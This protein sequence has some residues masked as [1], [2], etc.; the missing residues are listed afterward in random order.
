V[1]S[2]SVT[3]IPTNRTCVHVLSP[4]GNH[5]AQ[6]PSLPLVLLKIQWWNPAASASW[7]LLQAKRVASLKSSFNNLLQPIFYEDFLGPLQDTFLITVEDPQANGTFV[8]KC[9]QFLAYTVGMGF[10]F[11]FWCWFLNRSVTHFTCFPF[12]KA[13]FYPE[14]PI[15][16][17][18]FHVLN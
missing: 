9:S 14:P 6:D 16:Y 11:A 7:P 12:T 10:V 13:A 4:I 3:N 15:S 17:S 1:E 2:F 5:H 8:I 18:R